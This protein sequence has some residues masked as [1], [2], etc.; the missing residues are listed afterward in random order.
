VTATPLP[1]TR[2]RRSASQVILGEA[3][4]PVLPVVALFLVVFLAF[5]DLSA[6]GVLAPDVRDT[7]HL[8]DG[9][10]LNIAGGAGF[11]ATCAALPLGYAGDRLSRID[12]VVLL[13]L[14][15]GVATVGSALAPAVG[16]F[17]IARLLTGVG[18]VSNLPIQQS[19]L[20]DW[21]P[22]RLRPRAFAVHRL[23][24]PAGLI[25]GALAAGG[26]AQV[27]NWR[28]AFVV[29]GMPAFVFAYIAGLLRDP[30]RGAHEGLAHV[31]G[32][33]VRFSA[34]VRRLWLSRTLR[35]VWIASFVIGA[36][37]IPLLTLFPL[38]YKDVYGMGDF[39]R[40]VA[41]TLSGIAL[42]L[43][44]IAGG[45][46]G[47]RLSAT[48]VRGQLYYAG[49]SITTASLAVVVAA[50][51]HTA[52][53]S[54]AAAVVSSFLGGI[55]YAPLTQVL[56]LVSPPRIRSTGLAGAEFALGLGTLVGTA[57]IAAITNAHGDR[58][59]LA[60]AGV[61]LAGGGLIVGSAMT[62]AFEDA[63][64][65]ARELAV[66]VRRPRP[67]PDSAAAAAPLLEV[68]GVEFAY[69]GNQVL[70]GTTLEVR[71]GETLGLLGTNGAGKS[72]VLKVAAGIL[73]PHRGAVFHDGVEITGMAPEEVARRGVVLM[74]G[75]RA[76]FANLSV[77]E[78][79]RLATWLYRREREASASAVDEALELFPKLRGRIDQPAAVLSGGERQMLGVA[80]ALV[81]RPRLL[82][83]DELTLGLS[84][85][86]VEELLGVVGDLRARGLTLVVVEQSVN[87]AALLCERAY[88]M[89]KGRVRFCG[90]PQDLLRRPDLVRSVFLG[91]VTAK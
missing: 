44:L 74:P 13:A 1:V 78:N 57:I 48:T 65:A 11:L 72:T 64:A 91:A 21:Y 67:G 88:F 47:Q 66:Q 5:A 51:A 7:F 22:Q 6:S 42:L 58:A 81:C 55:Y 32:P 30:A 12:M 50:I 39:Q 70:F 80:Q 18:E 59:G 8:S 77:R 90:A 86:V 24:Q 53:F 46:L 87:I 4:H 15:L 19:L 68:V 3:G 62:S 2:T 54:V 34:A 23:G 40:G 49:V 83:L 26:I 14:V 84:P 9:T 61:I 60:T 82:L 45:A 56:S 29:V 73:S 31:A 43:G 89:E 79:L 75:G 25:V 35:R 36:G 71:P 27:S 69:E 41:A 33:P 52:A 37:Y 85:R 20:S 10:I 16:V 28:V 38:F 63:V 17:V 76:V